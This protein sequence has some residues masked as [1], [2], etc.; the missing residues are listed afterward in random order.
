MDD[1]TD[2]F[3][4][5][6]PEDREGPAVDPAYDVF[7]R[8]MEEH[9][10]G[11]TRAFHELRSTA[12][13]E[14]QAST[15]VSPPS[16]RAA[17]PPPARKAAPME[18]P[19]ANSLPPAAMRQ[20]PARPVSKGSGLGTM[21]AMGLIFTA[22]GFLL[23]HAWQQAQPLTRKGGVAAKSRMVADASCSDKEKVAP[24]RRSRDSSPKTAAVSPVPAPTPEP[25]PAASKAEA[26]AAAEST[27]KGMTL[28]A[29][30]LRK[31]PGTGFEI[32]DSLPPGFAL[33]GDLTTD[34]QWLRVK[35]G[36]FVSVD[37]VQFQDATSAGYQPYWVGGHIANIREFPLITAR[38][39]RKAQPGSELKLQAFN[40]EW[41]QLA[42]G[43]FVF[44][45]LVTNEAPRKLQLPAVMR[46]SVEK[47]EIRGGPGAQY[48]VLG[49]YFRNHKVEV[50][51]LESGW[52]RVG[53]DQYMRAQEL[54]L[55]TKGNTDRT[56]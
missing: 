17:P 10:Q 15:M 54:E 48:P 37:A 45:K 25:A 52:L 1:P 51:E 14:L 18:A 41:A 3:G 29:V 26:S 35:P 56:L 39:L 12:E 23:N 30:E 46:V 8:H 44:R 55:A 34:R 5:E 7:R 40:D 13:H 50:Q 38:I 9:I 49:L 36:A 20:A 4:S 47:A 22:I 42:D 27:L 28:R 31:G 33:E 11:E 16:R 24:S 21:V 2:I 6:R 32:V 53:P 19:K 43:G